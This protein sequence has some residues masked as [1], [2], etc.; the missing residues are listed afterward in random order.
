MTIRR[1]RGQR[2]TTALSAQQIL[3]RLNKDDNSFLTDEGRDIARNH[4]SQYF[5][6]GAKLD[7]APMPP[8]L[9]SPDQLWNRIKDY[10]DNKKAI[11]M[12]DYLLVLRLA[13]DTNATP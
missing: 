1:A 3:Q 9:I 11:A 4:Y 5:E 2:K 10:D 12:R 6:S 7:A 8:A 13:L